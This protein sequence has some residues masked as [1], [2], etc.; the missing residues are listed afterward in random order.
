LIILRVASGCLLACASIFVTL[1]SSLFIE[2]V[3]SHF[4]ICHFS[5]LPCSMIRIST[6]TTPTSWISTRHKQPSC[7]QSFRSFL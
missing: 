2:I 7:Q 6:G 1:A 4:V 5:F 3:V